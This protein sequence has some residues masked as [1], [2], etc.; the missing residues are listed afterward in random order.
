MREW[1]EAV[2]RHAART[3]E[4]TAYRFRETALTYGELWEQSG[5]LAAGL[6]EARLPPGRP[7]ALWGGKGPRM[8]QAMVGRLRAGVCYLPLESSYPPLRQEQILK[9]A[10]PALVLALEPCPGLELPCWAP[11]D[12]ESRP[13][14]LIRPPQPQPDAPAYLLY[15]SGSTGIPKGVL[16]SRR[17]LGAFCRWAQAL[18]FD[19]PR[20]REGQPVVLN[21]A[22]FSFD[23]SVLGFYPALGAGAQVFDLPRQ[24]TGDFPA[25]FEGLERSGATHWVST[26]SFAALCLGDPAFSSGLL[27]GLRQFFFCGETLPPKVAEQLFHR[28]P[29]VRIR[30]SYGPTEATVAVTAAEIFPR[31]CRSGEALP[32]GRVRPGCQVY[33]LDGLHKPVETGSV[34]EIFITGGSVAL[35]YCDDPE[36]TAH[37]FPTLSPE[38]TPARGYLTG[39]LGH[40][41]GDQLYFD[42]RADSQIKHRGN[43][44][45]LGDIE[46]NLLALE[47]VRQAVVLPPKTEQGPIRAFVTLT[48]GARETPASLRRR[49]GERLPSYLIPGRIAVLEEI[50]LNANGKADRVK[51]KEQQDGREDF[52]P[53]GPGHR[54]R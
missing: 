3:P 42:G 9:S 24:W 32:V 5:R 35:G 16:V 40:F 53:A 13:A 34:G 6:L 31:Q 10:R 4:R 43:R 27:P 50:P 54:N 26:P 14:G 39:D 1:L 18:L 30:N 47:A 52:G 48:R 22:P 45:E 51:L 28:F 20:D 41:C 2:A 19:S 8:A 12:W 23:L 49:L 44:V 11:Q 37:R 15:T 46:Q 7:V 36:R 33:L 38:G 17:N 21:Q 25:L 29:Q